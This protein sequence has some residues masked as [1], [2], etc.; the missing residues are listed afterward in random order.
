MVSKFVRDAYNKT[1]QLFPSLS[2]YGAVTAIAEDSKISEVLLTDGGSIK[3]NAEKFASLNENDQIAA[4]AHEL[5]HVSLLHVQRQKEGTHEDKRWHTAADI[6]TNGFLRPMLEEVG[7][8]LPEG[9]VVEPSLENYSVEEVYDRLPADEDQQPQGGDGENQGLNLGGMVGANGRGNGNGEGKGRA[10]GQ[11]QGDGFDSESQ[12]QAEA[13]K[14][15]SEA[16]SEIAGQL[17]GRDPMAALRIVQAER[18]RAFSKINKRWMSGMANTLRQQLG[19][20]LPDRRF[21]WQGLYLEN[22]DE[23]DRIAIVIDT[24]GSVNDEMVRVF[25][26]FV[27]GLLEDLNAEATVIMADAEIHTITNIQPG[28]PLPPVVGRGGTNFAPAIDWINEQQNGTYQAAFYFTDGYGYYPDYPCNV[29]M[30]WI[31]WPQHQKVRDGFGESIVM[32][33]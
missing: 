3:V 14:G 29:P 20:T 18:A 8:D 24:S 1:I 4:I 15:D 5:L 21:L 11:S 2:R 17:P 32:D 13:N 27:Q 26:E 19:V 23:E 30:Y 16:Q 9:S 7:L 25:L 22:Y 6:V 12:E 33:V 31:L 10:R 28:D